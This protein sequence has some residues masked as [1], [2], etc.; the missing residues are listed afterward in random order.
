M[1]KLLKHKSLLS[2]HVRR[3][4]NTNPLALIP[5]HEDKLDIMHKNI[6]QLG[7]LFAIHF[8]IFNA[9]YVPI[10]LIKL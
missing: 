2:S 3:N 1:F 6:V 4:M 7:N 9:I 10:I 5:L 8:F